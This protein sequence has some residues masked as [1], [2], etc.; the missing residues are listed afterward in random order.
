MN[1]I[2]NVWLSDLRLISTLL[3]KTSSL[4]GSWNELTNPSSSSSPIASAQRYSQC[5]LET[6]YAQHADL[7]FSLTPVKYSLFIN[8]N[9]FHRTLCPKWSLVR[10]KKMKCGVVCSPNQRAAL[11]WRM[12]WQSRSPGKTRNSHF[13]CLNWRQLDFFSW[14]LKMFPL[15]SKRPLQF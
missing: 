12:S 13:K 8:V 3:L 7:C 2:L 15:S 6:Y 4:T 10:R 14:F 11:L 9:K 5:L 1:C